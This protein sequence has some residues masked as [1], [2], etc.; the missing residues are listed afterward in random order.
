MTD[1][2]GPVCESGD[3]LALERPLA[4]VGP[5]NLLAVLGAGAYGFAMSSNYNSRA[6]AAEVLV[7]AGRWAVVRQRERLSD[8]FLG[9]V[10]DP[11]AGEAT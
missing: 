11:F 4:P 10:A 9:E 7:D 2:V 6:R 5:G 3:F 8:L 1:I